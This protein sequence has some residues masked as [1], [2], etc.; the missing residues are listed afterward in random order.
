MDMF[1]NTLAT[2]VR[3]EERFQLHMGRDYF[4]IEENFKAYW[5]NFI[6]KVRTF[7]EWCNNKHLSTPAWYI[8]DRAHTLHNI[9]EE[10][11]EEGKP[12]ELFKMLPVDTIVRPG[13]R[14]CVRRIS[15]NPLR[16]HCFTCRKDMDQVQFSQHKKL[17]VIKYIKLHPEVNGRRFATIRII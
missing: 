15:E 10:T 6:G 8:N 13:V 11:D 17:Y 7:Q 12:I 9:A 4:R 14:H 2:E 16:Y 1:L 5:S 3:P